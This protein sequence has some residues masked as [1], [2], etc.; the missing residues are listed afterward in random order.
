MLPVHYREVTGTGSQ[1]HRTEYAVTP[2]NSYLKSGSVLAGG[3]GGWETGDTGKG[4]VPGEGTDAG[5]LYD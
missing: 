3:G 1:R 2:V 4:N 5:T